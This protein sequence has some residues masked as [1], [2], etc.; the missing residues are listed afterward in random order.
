MRNQSC[1]FFSFLSINGLGT[2]KAEKMNVQ[3]EKLSIKMK[4]ERVKRLNG[5][6]VRAQE[7]D[8][9]TCPYR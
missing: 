5:Q 2:W 1:F 7:A 9:H 4:D 8:V 6:D 3:Y